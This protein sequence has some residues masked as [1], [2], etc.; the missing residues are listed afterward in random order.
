MSYNMNTI[1]FNI[2]KK[3]IMEDKEFVPYEEDLALKELGFNEDYLGY[4]ISKN[5]E[6]VNYSCMP[7]ENDILKAPLY[8]QAFRWFR[9]KYGMKFYIK[10]DNWNHWCTPMIHIPETNNYEDICGSHET[11]EESELACLRKL[12][13]IVK[14]KNNG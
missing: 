11:Y 5:L 14:E 9:K 6:I 2:L 1:N 12:I 7:Y 3:L 13:E 8:Q 10:E 4:Y